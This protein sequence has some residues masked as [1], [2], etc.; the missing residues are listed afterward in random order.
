MSSCK[1]GKTYYHGTD[2]ISSAL[3][4]FEQGI[5]PNMVEK[6]HDTTFKDRVYLTSDLESAM[7]Y[8]LGCDC[9]GVD[10]PESFKEGKRAYG[11]VFFVDWSS[12]EGRDVQPDEDS[13]GNVLSGLFGCTRGR[14]TS[15]CEHH[16]VEENVKKE[17]VKWLIYTAKERLSPLRMRKLIRYDEEFDLYRAGRQLLIRSSEYEIRRMIE[18]GITKNI[19][20]KGVVS[21]SACYMFDKDDSKHI[22]KDGSN[23]F[24]YARKVTIDDV[25][26]IDKNYKIIEAEKKEKEKLLDI[27]KK[28]RIT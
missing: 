7:I 12:I 4:I 27:K 18:S 9:F 5:R 26:Y 8:A 20:V 17:D 24:S 10:I 23:F 15:G 2:S 28:F 11:F 16:L 3:G 14:Q 13:V 19:A 22:K 21:P 6:H 25:R 1:I